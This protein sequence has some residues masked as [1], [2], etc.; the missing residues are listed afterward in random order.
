MHAR[1]VSPHIFAVARSMILLNGEYNFS[2]AEIEAI[3]EM[4][5]HIEHFDGVFSEDSVAA[6]VYSYWQYFFLGR[7]LHN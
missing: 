4:T 7:L 2:D 6:T 1:G 3:E 5:G